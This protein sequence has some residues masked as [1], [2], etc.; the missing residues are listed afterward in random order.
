VTERGRDS[1]E[2]GEAATTS[3]VP[4]LLSL[5]LVSFSLIITNSFS[6]K[7]IVSLLLLI[8]FI[9]LLMIIWFPCPFFCC[10]SVC[11]SVCLPALN[12][13]TVFNFSNHKKDLWLWPLL[14][15]DCFLSLTK[16]NLFF[17]FV[18]CFIFFAPGESIGA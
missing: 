9:Y 1:I 17:C 13:N 14:F 10:L 7:G 12:L 5:P 2:F 15:M 3:P 16:I 8:H 18:F 6:V 11:L 4:H